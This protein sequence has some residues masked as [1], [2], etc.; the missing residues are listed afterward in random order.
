MIKVFIFRVALYDFRTYFS[1]E[2]NK[3]SAEKKGQIG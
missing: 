2:I 1:L 3:N